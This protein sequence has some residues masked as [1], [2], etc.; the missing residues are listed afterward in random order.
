MRAADHDGER[1]RFGSFELDVRSRELRRGATT[2]ARLQEQPFEILRMILERPGEVVT[3][4]EL[5]Q[6]LW[7]NGTFVDFEHS[8]NAAVKRLRA[9]LGD[10]ASDPKFVET[11]PRR[12]YRFIGPR[13]GHPDRRKT[14]ATDTIPT[15]RLAVLPFANLSGGADQEFFV[16]GLTD[17]MIG[18][19]GEACR[20][21]IAI[22]ARTSSM[23]FKNSGKSARE[24]GEALRADYLLEGGVRHERDRVRITARLVETAGETQMWSQTYESPV[25]DYLTVQKDVSERIAGALSI[26][27]APLPRDADSTRR[28]DALAYQAYL[29]G[30]HYWNLVADTGTEQALLHLR[31]AIDLD[32]SFAAAHALLAR[33]LILR[34]EYYGAT[35]RSDLAAARQPAERA[36]ALDPTLFEAHL[37]AGDLSRMTDWDWRSAETEYRY[38]IEL[39]PSH[40]G[41]HRLYGLLLAALSRSA[42]AIDET[43]LACELD[44]LC[45]VANAGG[46]AWVN[47]LAGNYDTAIAR[48]LDGLE[49]EPRY[50]P[51]HRILG[52]AYLAAG[53]AQD[54]IRVLENVLSTVGRDPVL[55]ASLAHAHGV[56][57]QHAAARDLIEQLDEL[58]TSRHVSSYYRA[59]ACLGVG[60]VDAAF[61]ALERAAVDRDPALTY[62]SV[63]PQFESV[64]SDARF[65]ALLGRVGLAA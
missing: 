61:S 48:C 14:G 31:R 11:L 32:P 39:N 34:A 8:L 22:I 30:R 54:A 27:L 49:M 60:D 65:P 42:E 9:A 35:P 40:E 16:D 12:G 6:R 41:A 53:R 24:I 33:V 38:A 1:L 64:R 43:D 23:R 25:T 21:R 44:P 2:V 15:V 55:V 13:H 19:L 63:E 20:T 62:V 37:A 3:R 18:Q 17:E 4:E 58:G 50:V 26:R 7:P 45:V 51:A 57:G 59:L 52:A 10:D 36:L 47:Y 5:Q 46:V 56:A 29:R 28:R